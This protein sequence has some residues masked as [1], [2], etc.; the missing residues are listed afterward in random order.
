M[1]LKRPRKEQPKATHAHGSDIVITLS[2]ALRRMLRDAIPHSKS[3]CSSQRSAYATGRLLRVRESLQIGYYMIK[4]HEQSTKLSHA[5]DAQNNNAFDRQSN[6]EL[7]LPINEL[8]PG[9][10][11]PMFTE[12]ICL[13]RPVAEG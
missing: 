2:R 10:N 4:R 9:G 13:L 1:A 6:E 3:Q 5:R 8:C 7:T 12:H 11:L